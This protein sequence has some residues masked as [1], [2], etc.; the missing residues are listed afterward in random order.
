MI[1]GIHEILNA[2]K[3]FIFNDRSTCGTDLLG[4]ARNAD[5]Y[6][7]VAVKLLA[8][9]REQWRQDKATESEEYAATPDE[10]EPTDQL[11]G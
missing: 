5:M 1:K 7:L 6:Q 8:K 11:V 9:A 2:C 4:H 3:R 10:Q